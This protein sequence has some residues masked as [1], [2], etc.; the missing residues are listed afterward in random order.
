MRLSTDV[1]INA[2]L[3]TGHLKFVNIVVG[4]KAKQMVASDASQY[5]DWTLLAMPDAARKL[6]LRILPSVFVV[7]ENFK[8]I[9]KNLTVDEIKNSFN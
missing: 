4:D 6:D 3:E 5:P 9:N 1:N 7:D 8:I 2:A